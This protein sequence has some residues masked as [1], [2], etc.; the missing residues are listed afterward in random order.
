MNGM[1]VADARK[2]LVDAN[3][4]RITTHRDPTV[5]SETCEDQ[6]VFGVNDGETKNFWCFT[7]T[8]PVIRVGWEYNQDAN[9]SDEATPLKYLRFDFLIYNENHLQVTSTLDVYRFYY[10]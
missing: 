5:A 7:F 10:N 8:E 3:E 2:Q 9:T 4:R 1:D 6:C